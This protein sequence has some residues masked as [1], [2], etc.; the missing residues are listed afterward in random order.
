VSRES[1][2]PGRQHP[3]L[4]WAS[5]SLSRSMTD[6][7]PYCNVQ[8]APCRRPASI[9]S[10]TSLL[11]WA[12]NS[13]A[14]S[15][16]DLTPLSQEIGPYLR[17]RFTQSLHVS[18]WS[19]GDGL[20][21]EK[22]TLDVLGIDV[23]KRDL[24]AVL[25]Q[26]KR[27]TSKSVPNSG[28][29]IAQLQ[30]WLKNRKAER[31]HVCLEATGGWSEEVAFALGEAGHVV[32]LV[33][34]ARIKAFAQSELL[35]TKTDGI[36]AALIA[37]F[38]RLHEPEPW[39]PPAPEIRILQGLVRRQQSLIEMRVAEENR[40]DAP[41]VSAA[42][43]ASIEA[44]L[45]HYAREI[46]RVEREIKQ[47]FKDYPTL[48]RQRELLTSIPGIGEKTAAR[49]LGEIPNI[50][51]FRDV[52]AIAAYAG[53]SPRHYQSGSI[54][55]RSRLAKTGNAHLR[56]ALYFPA[57]TAVQHN[58]LIHEFAERLRARGAKSKMTVIAAAMRKLLTLA[59][60]VLKSGRPFDPTYGTV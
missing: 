33:N 12:S 54:E 1:P 17:P 50:V 10:A 46:E 18:G 35:R 47:L 51:E 4:L 25:L 14:R 30:T 9:G 19:F 44:T 40:R 57:I 13:L 7:P 34:P 37:R 39:K 15:M 53:L 5:S 29:G 36:D 8:E 42:V 22:S 38:C 23:G 49:I 48:R 27:S 11:R 43:S 45:E 60:G 56:R 52:K 6:P 2:R 21:L 32:S 3:W 26:E 16:T 20:S 28:A 59:Y 58:P 24:H 55:Y 31:V 41:L